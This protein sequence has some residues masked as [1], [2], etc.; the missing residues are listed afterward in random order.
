M[1]CPG[2][3]TTRKPSRAAAWE[4]DM[5]PPPFTSQGGFEINDWA[6]DAFL[7]T[8]TTDGNVDPR[9]FSTFIWNYPGAMIY[10]ETFAD[11]YA[12]NLNF[13]GGRKY[14][15][16]ETPDKPLSDFGFAGFPSVINWRV[17]RYA[18]VL[19]MYAEAENEVNGP[20]AA[21]FDA[22]N[23]VRQRASMPSCPG[24]TRKHCGRPSVGR[25]Y[26]NYPWREPGTMT[27]SAGG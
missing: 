26:W 2:G 1:A 19:L 25:G 9:T 7:E 13:V 15:D 27:C 10:Q 14:L 18:D 6:F 17:I 3:R 23:R 4:P 21:V 8:P 24:W 5:A 16:F 22:L 11:A 12:T 20:S